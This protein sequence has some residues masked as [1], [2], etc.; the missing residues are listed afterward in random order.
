MAKAVNSYDECYGMAEGLQLN[1]R[2]EDNV[3]KL[4]EIDPRRPTSDVAYHLFEQWLQD[5]ASELSTEQR[6]RK[7]NGVFRV[8]LHRAVL[9]DILSDE[10]RTACSESARRAA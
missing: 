1:I 5:G 4:R 7:L 2:G 9:C 3:K 8:N 6:R 10:L